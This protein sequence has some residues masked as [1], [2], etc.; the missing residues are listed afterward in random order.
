MRERSWTASRAGPGRR[1]SRGTGGHPWLEDE[2]L[3]LFEDGDQVVVET[4]AAPV[5]FLLVSGCPL[6]EPV[7]W[8]G[9]IVMNTQEELDVAFEEYR[10]G[11]F[12]RPPED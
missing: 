10:T 3:I 9:P 2:N 1:G 12:I 4:G 5:R 7:A 11:K 8:R 6:G